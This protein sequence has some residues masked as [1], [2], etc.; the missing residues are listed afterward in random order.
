MK[1]ADASAGTVGGKSLPARGR[2]EQDSVRSDNR[3]PH[4]V[5]V[6]RLGKLHVHGAKTIRIVPRERVGG[7]EGVNATAT[8]SVKDLDPR[9]RFARGIPSILLF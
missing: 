1:G 7:G 3:G 6:R 2:Y 4:T 5:G 9:R 8:I